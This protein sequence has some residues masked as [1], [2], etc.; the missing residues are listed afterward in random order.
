[1]D[2][3]TASPVLATKAMAMATGMAAVIKKGGRQARHQPLR[4]SL[5]V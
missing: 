5:R 2:D 4:R 3:V 1:M